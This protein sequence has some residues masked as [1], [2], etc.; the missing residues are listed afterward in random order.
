MVVHRA[1]QEEEEEEEEK[2]KLV[3]SPLPSQVDSLDFLGIIRCKGQVQQSQTAEHMAVG[4]MH[5]DYVN[6]ESDSIKQVYPKCFGDVSSS[7][8]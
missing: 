3:Y 2:K 4:N 8:P 1:V 6:C 7:L 5:N